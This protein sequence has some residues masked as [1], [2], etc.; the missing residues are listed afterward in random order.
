[1]SSIGTLLPQLQAQRPLVHC[2]TN[3]VTMNFVADAL[4]AVSARP[5]MANS[6][7]EIDTIAGAASALLVNIGVPQSAALYVQAAKAADRWVFDPVGAGGG[8]LRGPEED[9]GPGL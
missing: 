9:Q 5:I 3:P 2:V 8:R 7:A 4:N 6:T 1:M